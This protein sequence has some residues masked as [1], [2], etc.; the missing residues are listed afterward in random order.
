[1]IFQGAFSVNESLAFVRNE[2]ERGGGMAEV[3]ASVVGFLPFISLH[4]RSKT[5][6][7]TVVIMLSHRTDRLRPQSVPAHG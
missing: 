1:M 2:C 4:K 3:L 7:I 5:A 6:S